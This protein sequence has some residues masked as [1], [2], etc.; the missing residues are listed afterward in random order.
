MSGTLRI[1][2]V[3]SLGKVYYDLKYLAAFGSATNLVKARKNK[4]LDV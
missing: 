3:M 4:E 1:V 2:V